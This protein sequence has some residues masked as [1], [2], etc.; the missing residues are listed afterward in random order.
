MD[1]RL[2]TPHEI[3]ADG[4]VHL[5]GII[6][7]LIGTAILIGI[8]ATGHEPLEFIALL[9]YS[10]SLL[11]VLACSAAYNHIRSNRHRDL[12]QRFDNSA[13]FVMIAG[14]YTPFT[15]LRLETGWA[16]TLTALVWLVATTGVAVRFLRP[17]LFDRLSI[18][19]YLALGW[20]GVI[21][22]KP[23]LASLQ[24]STFV[25]LL[26]GGMLYSV[27]VIFHVWQRLRF[28]NAIWHGF[29]VAAAAVHYFAVLDEIAIAHTAG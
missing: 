16:I 1:M 29:V 14:T 8:G 2:P 22:A 19:F 10:G 15:I 26:V 21:A 13:I 9:I 23:F 17:R 12:L 3:I 5:V 4:L 27:G 20:I 18:A 11:G 24:S 25:L 7:A 6:A 28:Q